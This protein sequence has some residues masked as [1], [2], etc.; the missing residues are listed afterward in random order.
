MGD[1]LISVPEY[2]QQAIAKAIADFGH[3]ETYWEESW[4]YRDHY[5]VNSEGVVYEDGEIRVPADKD[6]CVC[7]GIALF[8]GHRFN[9]KA[10]WVCSCGCDQFRVFASDFYETSGTCAQCGKTSVLHD[11]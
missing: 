8:A 5:L 10:P 1:T 9:D 3:D 2:R 4:H 7:A 11:G 6:N